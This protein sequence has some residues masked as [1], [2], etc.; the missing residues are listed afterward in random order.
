MFLGMCN[1]YA[2]FVEKYVQVA[3]LLYSLLRKDTTWTWA[4]SRV[5][6][7]VSW[8]LT[9]AAVHGINT[10]NVA[11]AAAAIAAA[12]SSNSCSTQQRQL[13]HAAATAAARSSDSCSTQQRQLQHAAVTAAARSSDSCSTQQ[14]QLQHAAATAAARSITTSHAASSSTRVPGVSSRI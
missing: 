7:V 2:K 11:A 1:Y 8:P 6:A 13:Q 14:R 10:L 3:A 5:H 9:S 4:V 12:C